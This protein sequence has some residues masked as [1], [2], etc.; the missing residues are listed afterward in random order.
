[1]TYDLDTVKRKV[2]ARYPYFGSIL[3]DITIVETPGSGE[4]KSSGKEL[5]YDPDYLGG[6]KDTEQIFALAHEMCYI[7]FGHESRGE[8]KDQRVWQVASDA[9]I[10]QWLARDGMQIP[11]GEVDLPEAIEYDAEEY[12]DLLMEEQLDIDLAGG[13]LDDGTPKSEAVPSEDEP[14]E[15]QE[16]EDFLPWD[17]EEELPEDFREVTAPSPEAGN[18]VNADTRDMD[19]IGSAIP[20]ID[21]R[22]VLRDTITY[23]VDWS[24]THAVI[25][26]GIVRPA[27]EER[28]MP[29]TEIVLDTSWSV[30]EDLLRDFLRECKNVL[31]HSKLK[32]GC[33]DTRFYGFHEIK[34][35]KDIEEMVFDGGGGTDFDVAVG[36]FSLRV[37]NRIIF[38]DG[39]APMPEKPMDAIWLVYGD[40]EIAP[41]GG[42]VIHISKQ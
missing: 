9:V 32:A 6:R 8:G 24:F 23:G 38:T 27:L 14:D 11:G 28:P 17:E 39:K 31:K 18:A 22:L 19:E 16:L 26:D 21:W 20:A 30:E 4:I 3:A 41:A 12:Y 42:R 15:D 2:L 13:N 33:F 1:M 35:D 36:A 29:E 10:N 7:A 34:T 37:D 5:R 25:E 40:E